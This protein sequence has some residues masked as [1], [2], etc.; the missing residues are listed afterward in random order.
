MLGRDNLKGL[1]NDQYFCFRWYLGAYRTRKNHQALPEY[2]LRRLPLVN[3]DATPRS[4]LLNHTN[5]PNNQKSWPISWNLVK[6]REGFSKYLLSKSHLPKTEFNNLPSNCFDVKKRNFPCIKATAL[7]IHKGWIGGSRATQLPSLLYCVWIMIDWITQTTPTI[8]D[9]P[10]LFTQE[11]IIDFYKGTNSQ[12]TFNWSMTFPTLNVWS[13]VVF[14][15]NSRCHFFILL[16]TLTRQQSIEKLAKA[17][18][19]GVIPSTKDK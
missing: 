17:D 7:H 18:F 4:T 9:S 6:W 12:N 13:S 19:I 16:A 14:R 3:C 5:D 8:T 10:Y 15:R 2:E 11:G 1:S